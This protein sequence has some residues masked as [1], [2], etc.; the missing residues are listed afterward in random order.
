MRTVLLTAILSLCLL[1]GG[2]LSCDTRQNPTE[3]REKTAQATAELK[4]DAK[5]VAQGVREGWSRNNPLDI[6]KATREQL[7]TLPGMTGER[8][9]RLIEQRPYENTNEL[10]KRRV[11]SQAEYERIQDRIVA[12]K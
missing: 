3:L 4:Q 5:A 10:V 7:V 11:L 8:A 12:K 9:D 1:A 2:C 6:N